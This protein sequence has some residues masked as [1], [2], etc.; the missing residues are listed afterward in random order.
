[1]TRRLTQARHIC[2][3]TTL[4]AGAIFPLP[5]AGAA[6]LT[7]SALGA[8]GYM[9]STC[10]GLNSGYY[11]RAGESQSMM[12]AGSLCNSGSGNLAAGSAAQ[13]AGLTWD[14]TWSLVTTTQAAQ[15]VSSAGYG[16]AKVQSS[17]QGVG[18]AG[19]V[20]GGATAGWTD[21]LTVGAV[22][23]A[24]VGKAALFNFSV[25]LDGLLDVSQG[26]ANGAQAALQVWLNDSVY[27]PDSY[28]TAING[29]GGADSQAVNEWLAFSAPI[30]LGSAFD[31]GVASRTIASITSVG[32]SNYMS[33]AS[34]DFS[35]TAEWE[36]VS[37]V[38]VGG[39]S[40]D[41]TLASLSGVDWRVPYVEV[42]SV[43]EPSTLALLF[44]GLVALGGSKLGGK[45]LRSRM[46]GR[47]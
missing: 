38:T 31:L 39:K 42:T 14:H 34:A 24:D 43:P 13:T 2:M 37:S 5:H 44:A 23:P 36:G 6:E 9:A 40:V 19:F 45:R 35:H 12:A 25:H 10:A 22:D 46:C 47:C 3:L 20:H 30:K 32:P 27:F 11:G 28:T 7:L 16:W 21:R 15:A 17:F 33:D 8:S 29:N 41:Y 4:A 26:I 1:M 18:S